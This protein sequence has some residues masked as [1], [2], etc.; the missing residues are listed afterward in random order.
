M[1]PSKWLALEDSKVDRLSV[2][3]F[4]KATS[5]WVFKSQKYVQRIATNRCWGCSWG[6][7]D[8]H[9]FGKWMKQVSMASCQRLALDACTNLGAFFEMQFLFSINEA[10]S[11]RKIIDQTNVGV[12]LFVIPRKSF[13]HGDIT[14]RGSARILQILMNGYF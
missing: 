7:P 14:A 3:I 9:H 13:G 10:G 4:D 12:A 6:G 1:Y 5:T 8:Q 2:Y 11:D